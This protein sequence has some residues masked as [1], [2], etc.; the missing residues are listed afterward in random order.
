VHPRQSGK[1]DR[2]ADL[3]AIRDTYD[4][5]A[6]VGRARLWDERAPGYARLAAELQRS[7]LECLES[8]IPSEGGRVL[9]LGCG[10][11]SLAA[12]AIASEPTDW[13][14]VDLRPEAVAVAQE[15]FPDRTFVVASA[16]EVP[17]DEESVDVVVARLLFSS[18]PS[19]ELEASVA[20]EVRRL[21]RPGGWLVWLDIRYANPTNHAV[22]GL[23]RARIAGLFPGWRQELRPSG[24]LPPLARRLGRTTRVAYPALSVLPLLRSHLVGRLQRP[25]RVV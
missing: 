21:L 23:S 8:S 18:L 14:G 13:V 16:D 22:H 1:W 4:R 10:D 15:R 12:E 9:D 25:A 7:L 6:E 11:G 5:Y 19:A 2:D 17:L 24:L 20:E 3:R